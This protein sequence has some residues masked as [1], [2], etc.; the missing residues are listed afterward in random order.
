MTEELYECRPMSNSPC[1]ICCK[2][3]DTSAIAANVVTTGSQL[4][5]QAASSLRDQ[6]PDSRRR[7]YQED[8]FQGF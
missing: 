5:K 2:R 3:C 8:E 6:F 4:G 1:T 7:S